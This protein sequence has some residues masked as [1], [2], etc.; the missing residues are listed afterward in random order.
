MLEFLSNIVTSEPF[1]NTLY[2]VAGLTVLVGAVAYVRTGEAAPALLAGAIAVSIVLA[3]RLLSWF[4]SMAD[5]LASTQKSPEAGSTASPSTSS[6]PSAT[7]PAT[8][9]PVAPAQPA[10]MSWVPTTLLIIAALVVGLFVVMGLFLFLTK[11]VLP[12]VR[13]S[14]EQ[15][16]TATR[17]LKQS[18]DRL[19]EV[20]T[21]YGRYEL[22]LALQIDYPAMNDVSVPVVRNF[23]T[24]LR[25]AININDSLPDKPGPG[26]LQEF[27][28]AVTDAEL[29]F[30]LAET[31]VRNT[32]WK[33]LSPAKRK[34]IDRAKTA[35]EQILS[36][37]LSDAQM[38]A[39]WRRLES[40]LDG[41]ITITEKTRLALAARVPL[42]A[43]ESKK[44]PR[45]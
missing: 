13:D 32:G 43:L 36:G 8:S 4:R 28:T 1:M 38:A 30:Q 33:N 3:P 20:T 7:T 45:H 25:Q 14:R 11:K 12:A 5:A 39:M 26:R 37:A 35:L 42:G 44:Q 21:A 18:R 16:L 27:A 15:T 19:Q 24:A 10:D 34:K 9:A 29:N 23:I 17:T 6:M 31:F 2:I 41:I 40:S 22:D